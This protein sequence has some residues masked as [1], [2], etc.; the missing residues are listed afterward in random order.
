MTAGRKTYIY[1]GI[2]TLQSPLMHGGETGSNVTPFRREKRIAADGRVKLLPFLSGNSLKHRV[3]RQPGVDFMIQVLGLPDGWLGD[4]KEALHLLY[5]GGAM[6][7]RGANIDLEA[8]RDLCELVPILGLCGGALGNHM[9]ESYLRVGDAIPI[10][11][12]YL[13]LIPDDI[14]PDGDVVHRVE[15]LMDLRFLTRQDALR[16]HTQRRMLTSGD[17]EQQR[18]IESRQEAA[19]EGEKP[20]E[21]SR[22]MIAHQEVMLAGTRLYWPLRAIE[23][24]DIQHE[25]LACAI[26]HWKMDPHLGGRSAVGMGRADLV[27]YGWEAVNHAAPGRTD[28]DLPLGRRYV[29]HLREHREEIVRTIRSVK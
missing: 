28:V 24:T 17:A 5:S 4:N 12:D 23:I 29:E 10:C 19:E 3:I 18:L 26:A 16:R 9:E 6:S 14:K 13:H 25:A 1:D 8:W 21:K 27:L 20:A 7:K 15:D 11:A 2:I 22:Q